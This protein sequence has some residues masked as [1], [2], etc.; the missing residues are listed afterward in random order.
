MQPV[1]VRYVGRSSTL[2]AAGLRAR[3]VVAFW[4]GFADQGREVQQLSF[5]LVEESFLICQPVNFPEDQAGWWYCDL[6]RTH[7]GGDH[8]EI[9]DLYID[10]LIG[11]PTVPY[12]VLDLD[13]FGEAARHGLMT[14][15]EAADGLVRCQHFLDRRLNRRH[16]VTPSWPEFPPAA[17]SDF[18]RDRLPKRWSW[19]T[20]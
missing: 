3:D 16:D 2:V 15:Q 4:W 6:V 14:T 18:D 8:V 10:I 13:E 12:R 5:L 17:I 7:D 1:E 20:V 9:E 11:P 19:Q